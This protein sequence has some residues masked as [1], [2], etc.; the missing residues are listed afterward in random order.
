MVCFSRD[1]RPQGGKYSPYQPSQRQKGNGP[2]DQRSRFSHQWFWRFFPSRMFSIIPGHQDQL[3]KQDKMSIKIS[4]TG[5]WF[6]QICSRTAILIQKK[7][8]KS[9]VCWSGESMDT[10]CHHTQRIC[11]WV[12]FLWGFLSVHDSNVVLYDKWQLVLSSCHALRWSYCF[13]WSCLSLS[14][15]AYHLIPLH[16]CSMKADP[17]CFV[18]SLD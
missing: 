12:L 1:I 13:K 16:Y 15:T 4:L 7:H 9:S 8:L 5:K 17:K 14:F 2:Q 3:L 10:A 11:I 18:L 6:S